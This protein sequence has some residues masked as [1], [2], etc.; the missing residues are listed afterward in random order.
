MIAIRPVT[1][2]RWKDL[3]ALFEAKGGPKYCWCMAWRARGEEARLPGPKRK[4]LLKARV[5]KGVPIGLLAYE[6][7]EPIGWCSLAPKDTYARLDDLHPDED[8]SRV[9]SIACFWIKREFRGQ[10]LTTRFVEAAIALARKRKAK[11]IEAYP[12]D[13]DSPSYRFMG[14]VPLFKGEGFKAIGK[15]G[16]RRHVMRL[17]LR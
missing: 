11:A 7:K 17:E 12:V 14:F 16:T 13:E 4:P 8:A 6:G 15:A 3:E 1:R 9:W 10:G 2:S 5:D